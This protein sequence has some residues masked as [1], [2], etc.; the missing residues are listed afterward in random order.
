[1][2]TALTHHLVSKYTSLVAVDKTPVRPAGAG[3]TSEQVANLMPYGQSGA[4]IFG[5][6]ATATN[7][8]ILRLTGF[9]ALLAAL[10]FMAMPTFGRKESHELVH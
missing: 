1:V 3:L 6:P 2:E 10:L 9:A 5:M 4:V 7:A 8:E